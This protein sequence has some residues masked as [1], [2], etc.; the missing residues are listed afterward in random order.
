MKR[1]IKVVE[2]KGI[3]GILVIAFAITCLIAGFVFF[4]AWAIMNLWNLFSTYIYNIPQMNFIHGFMLYTI[5][6]L[7][8]FATNS[9]KSCF[10]ITSPKMTKS[11]IATLLNDIDEEK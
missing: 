10:G 3:K 7:L 1:Q 4:P 2:I 9:H 11:N 8:Y 6:V 5:F